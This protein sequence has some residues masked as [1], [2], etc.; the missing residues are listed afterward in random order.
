VIDA[1]GA[2]SVAVD[3]DCATVRREQ[4]KKTRHNRRMSATES[5]ALA[6]AN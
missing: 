4:E 1:S 3:G 2:E 5:Q 6:P